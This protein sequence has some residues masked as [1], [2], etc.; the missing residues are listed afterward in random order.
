MLLRDSRRSEAESRR[1]ES[2]TS[3]GERGAA[4]TSFFLFLV[5]YI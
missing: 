4:S 3:A 2:N 5:H 1:R